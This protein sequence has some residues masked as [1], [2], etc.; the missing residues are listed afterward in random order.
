MIAIRDLDGQ[1]RIAL[2]HSGIIVYTMRDI[3]E[4]GMATVRC[5]L[6]R[7]NR[8]ERIHVSFDMDALEPSGGGGASARRWPAASPSRGAPAH[9]D[10]GRAGQGLPRW[11]SSRST[12]S[13]RGQP[14]RG[15]W[16]W[17]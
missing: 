11:T 14:H 7:L 2:A 13:R 16:L 3:D 4:L 17:S 12:Y 10:P 9:G 8:L 1:E 6:A 5:A 15:R